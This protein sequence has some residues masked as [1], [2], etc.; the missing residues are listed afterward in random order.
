MRWIIQWKTI[1]NKT[2]LDY[3][4]IQDGVTGFLFHDASLA[5][6]LNAIYRSLDVFSSARRLGAM[7]RAAMKRHFGWQRSAKKYTEVY[8]H[9]ARSH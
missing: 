6:M 1:K 5:P 3:L 8:E 4:L 2:I 9:A 7:R